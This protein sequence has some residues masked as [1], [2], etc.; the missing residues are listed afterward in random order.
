M[1]TKPRRMRKPSP[2]ST[3]GA[4][5]GPGTKVGRVARLKLGTATVLPRLTTSSMTRPL[6]RR[7]STGSRI[8]TS[9][10][11]S[12]RPASLRGANVTSAMRS[13]A[14]CF[15]S[16]AKWSVPFSSS[17]G[18][19]SANDTPL[20]SGRRSLI[21]NRV[22][23]SL[24]ETGQDFRDRATQERVGQLVHLRRFGVQNDD[25]RAGPLG[26]RHHAGDGIYRQL[27][28]DGQHQV[29]ARGRLLGAEEIV[30]HKALTERNRGRLEDASTTKAGRVR[31]AGA[32]AR[33]RPLHGRTLAAR[34]ADD[35]VHGAVDLDHPRR[36]RPRLHV[37][38]V[39]VLGDERVELAPALERDK[40]AM[41]VVRL[42]EPCR[43]VEPALPRVLAHLGIGD[44]VLQGRLLLGL[45]ILR[46]DAL[47]PAE[48]GN[49]GIGRD[50]GAGERH[51][52][53]GL[54]DPAANAID[55]R[56]SSLATAPS[57]TVPLKK[58]GFMAVCRRAAFVKT[59]SRKSSWVMSPCST[60]SCA[61]SST[62]V[63]SVTS[64]CPTSE[65]KIG[66]RR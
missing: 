15:G 63:M 59:N 42:R 24:H 44:V 46:P 21:S 61:S 27:G 31:L 65:L 45:G 54:F 62:S 22:T 25:A 37:Q 5:L 26:D 38:A 3:G 29:A 53:P 32:H 23:S 49:A 34:Q 55:Q 40:S 14:A 39:D 56:S 30:L 28:T 12:T 48:V 17:Y 6:H 7:R 43:R 20:A 66:F 47:R 58:S 4:G 9:D 13:L 51:Q 10:S 1:T 52:A 60:S 2:A 35:L 19:A 33:Q 18:P 8:D 11:N 57:T 36:R 41:A 16:T 50:A 64:K